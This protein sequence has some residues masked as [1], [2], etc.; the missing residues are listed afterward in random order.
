MNYLLVGMH[1]A[2]FNTKKFEHFNDEVLDDSVKDYYFKSNKFRVID[3]DTLGIIDL[4]LEYIIDNNLKIRCLCVDYSIL[5]KDTEYL[6]LNIFGCDK[7]NGGIYKDYNIPVILNGS[8]INYVGYYSS[9]RTFVEL[10]DKNSGLEFSIDLENLGVAIF[11]N[12]V[13]VYNFGNYIEASRNFLG[14]RYSYGYNYEYVYREMNFINDLRNFIYYIDYD[15]CYIY[16]DIYYIGKHYSKGYIVIPGGIKVLACDL[17]F[18]SGVQSIV[19][20][21]TIDLFLVSNYK[22][23]KNKLKV[24]VSNDKIANTIA[25]FLV[26]YGDYSRLGSLAGKLRDLSSD[27]LIKVCKDNCGVE[28][29]MYK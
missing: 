1:T 18:N 24:Y 27:E 19:L 3:L 7:S 5:T 8:I 28:F 17:E 22:N 4:D 2:K 23:A 12:T 10:T 20:P 6:E 13:L 9:G 29:E 25:D 21:N 11:F 26:N 15:M 16:G 14:Y